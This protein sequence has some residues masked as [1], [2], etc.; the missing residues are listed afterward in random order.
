MGSTENISSSF[1]HSVTLITLTQNLDGKL[2]RF[3][4]NVLIFSTAEI[5]YE[6]FY[7]AQSHQKTGLPS[8][9]WANH[10]KARVSLPPTPGPTPQANGKLYPQ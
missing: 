3:Y 1:S 5:V 9:Q 2:L 10:P 7:T 4:H 6:N 8:Q